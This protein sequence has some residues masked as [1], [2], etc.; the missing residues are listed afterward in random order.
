MHKLRLGTRGSPLALIQA[1]EVATS[2]CAAHG[3]P[4]DAVDFVEIRTTGDAVQDRPL[5]EIGGKALWTKEIDRALLAG[6]IDVA[7]HSTK[8]IES[9]RPAEIV[10]AATLPRADVRERLI[11]LLSLDNLQPGT[12]V[13]TTSPRRAA[14]LRAR[15]PGIVIVPFRGNVAT[16][17]DR[18]ARGEADATL[19]ANAGLSRLGISVGSIVPVAE[20]LPCPGQGAIGIECR[21]ND[22]ATR[23]LLAAIDNPATTIAVSAERSLA[24][25]LGGS[26][27]SPVAALAVPAG[28]HFN[29][30]AEILAEDGSERVAGATEFMA[31]GEAP[32]GQRLAAELL[33]R[34]SPALA[35]QFSGPA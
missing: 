18:I 21:A 24:L 5:A 12:R 25:A 1:R 13:G 6:E 33:A 30:S 4:D 29:L 35:R 23:A 2:L 22:D 34:A 32:A 14:Q 7:V 3:W 9:L 27:H 26:C 20:M 17:L 19:L 10:F 11:G 31:G 16:R 8:D 15:C 28:A